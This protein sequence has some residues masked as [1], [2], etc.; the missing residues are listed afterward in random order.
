MPMPTATTAPTSWGDDAF[1]GYARLT[2]LEANGD[3]SASDYES[4]VGVALPQSSYSRVQI[5]S[6]VSLTAPRADFD[7]RA[8]SMLSVRSSAWSAMPGRT[9]AARR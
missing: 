2:T 7:L 8:F 5:A 3:A 1:G 6:S 9:I 4:I